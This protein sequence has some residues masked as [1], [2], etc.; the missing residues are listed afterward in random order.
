[1]PIRSL[2][3]AAALAAVTLLA[4]DTFAQSDRA[5]TTTRSGGVPPEAVAK[6]NLSDVPRYF[7]DTVDNLNR[8][9]SD[10]SRRAPGLA[11]NNYVVRVFPVRNTEAI[12]I[13]S[14]L[15]RAL[16]YEGGTAEVMGSDNVKDSGA[17][18]QYLYVTAPDFMMPGIEELVKE[19]DKQGFT[20]YDATAKTFGGPAGALGYA[21]KHRTAT[22][23]A[24]ILKGT[25]LGNV[26]AFLFPP[27]ADDATNRIYIVDNPGDMADNMAALDY[28]DTP[29]LQVDLKV[30]IYEMS[31][32]DNGKLGLDWDIWKSA[33]TGALEY[34]S[35]SG[36]TFFNADG[37][38]FSTLLTLD[39]RALASFINYT[40][41]TG[42]S[43][44]LTSTRLTMVNSEDIPGGLS[45]GSKGA[46]TGSA[47]VIESTIPIPYRIAQ[48]EVGPTNAHNDYNEVIDQT[49]EG[50]RV[51]MTPFIGTESITINFNMQVNSL[52]GYSKVNDTPLVSTRRMNSVLNIRGGEMLIAGGLDREST[53]ESRVGIPGLKEIPV[54]QYL[55]SKKSKR[56]EKTKVVILLEPAIK[57]GDTKEAVS[58][59]TADFTKK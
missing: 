54:L 14:Y 8:E 35:L 18:L 27:F 5:V 21:G 47:A 29:P 44:V 13:Q 38:A 7:L 25:E 34:S 53:T 19:S 23:L 57:G 22:E 59:A 31:G 16:A 15:L 12:H 49:F 51:E 55:F 30:T 11:K 20:F 10:D 39:A 26:G 42:T 45:G 58:E 36:N 6:M 4:A 17:R 41:Q 46:S 9:T 1:M 2:T 48:N 28:F 32:I 43:K 52:V 50:V 56:T 37:D 40:V 3:R 33:T 24:A